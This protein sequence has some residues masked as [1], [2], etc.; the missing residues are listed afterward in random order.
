[1]QKVI[2]KSLDLVWMFD[3]FI[4]PAKMFFFIFSN[5]DCEMELSFCMNGTCFAKSPE[6]EKEKYDGRISSWSL[7]V[8]IFN[9][10]TEK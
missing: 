10:D 9:L 7:C 5:T 3:N 8:N 6:E 1:M 4:F 2:F